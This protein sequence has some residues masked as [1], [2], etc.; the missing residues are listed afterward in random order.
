MPRVVVKIVAKC[1]AVRKQEKSCF[2]IIQKIAA[3]IME[4]VSI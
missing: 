3:K 2:F 4:A 1:L